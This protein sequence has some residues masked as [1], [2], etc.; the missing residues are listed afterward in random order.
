MKRWGTSLL[1]AVRKAFNEVID[2]LI[3]CGGLN[4]EHVHV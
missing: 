2:L 4:L 1:K 3:I